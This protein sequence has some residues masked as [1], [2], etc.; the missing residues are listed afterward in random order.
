MGNATEHP[1]RKNQYAKQVVLSFRVLGSI[2]HQILIPLR[3]ALIVSPSPF[4]EYD[5]AGNLLFN[6]VSIFNDPSPPA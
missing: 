6:V 3:G 2:S 5:F 4:L 1:K